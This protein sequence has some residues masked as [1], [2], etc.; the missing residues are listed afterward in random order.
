MSEVEKVFMMPN[1]DVMLGSF[2]DYAEMII[3]F[4]YSTMFVSAFPLATVMSLVNNYVEIRVDTWKICHLTKRP[5]PRSC[6]DIGT[7]YII[8]E[9]ISFSAVFVNSALVAFTGAQTLNY[10]WV[11]R[12]WFFCLMSAGLAGIRL[13]VAYLVPDVPSEVEIQLKR[14]DYIVDKVLHNVPDEG[15]DQ[16]TSIARLPMY[17]VLSTDDDPL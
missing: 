15:Q 7:W 11:E 3:Q 14:Q 10:T 4:G 13:L 8:L 9:A 6:E 1:Y 2:E 12:V 5:E 16:V 17:C